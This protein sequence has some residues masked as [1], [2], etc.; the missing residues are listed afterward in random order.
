MRRLTSRMEQGN[1]S[2]VALLV[3]TSVLWG[4]SFVSIKIGLTFVD[5][6]DFAFLRSIITASILLVVLVSRGS[7]R[8]SALREPAVW[9]LGLVSGMGYLFQF[10][11]LEYTTA[12][13]TALLI[14][15]NVI[16]VAILS[17]KIFGESFGLRKQ[18]GVVLGAVGAALITTN[19]DLSGLAQGQLKGDLFAFVSGLIFAL[20]IVIH[21]RLQMQR[22]RNVIEMSSVVMLATTIFL[23]P[24]ALLLGGLN[25]RNISLE[26]W[27]WVAFTAIACTVI[28]YALWISALKAVTATIA[29]VVGLLEIVAAMVLSTV[30]LGE[31]Y[32]TATLLGA[33]LVLLSILAVAE[34]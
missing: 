26:G 25:M 5:P 28:P 11:G 3:I 27:G 22:D 14:D 34:S 16:V 23:F 8:S 29:S 24:A 7:F 32:S 20:F 4:S 6:Y 18:L 10:L 13:K 17:W 9:G 1:N 2:A 33:I 21:K 12:A 31:G 15:L 19:G 30:L